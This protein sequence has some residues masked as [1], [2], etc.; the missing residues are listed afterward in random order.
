MN[1]YAVVWLI[2][3]ITLASSFSVAQTA[4]IDSLKKEF[5]QQ[6]ND[7][8][9]LAALVS[10]CNYHQSINK[11]SLYAY[12]LMANS[13]SAKTKTN[14]TAAAII[15][16]NA[17][18]RMGKTD[19]ALSI[20]ETNLTTNTVAN[21]ATRPF[22]F[23]LSAIKA[24]CFGDAANYT[25]ALAQLYKII[26]EAET[27][28]DPIVLAKN[29]NTIGVIQYNLDHVPEAFNWYFKGLSYTSPTPG[30]AA[31][32]GALYINLAETY[33]WVG[34]TD[35]ATYF[36]DKAIPLCTQSQ[37]LFFLGNA[38]RVKASI[39]KQQKDY[40]K[41]EETMLASIAI[42]EKL[43]GKLRFSNE[44]IALANI[45]MNAGLYDKAI[46]MLNR[47]LAEDKDETKADALII[48]YYSTLAKCYHQKGDTKNYTSTLEKII[49]A[50]DAFYEA[51]SAQAIAELQTKYELQKKEKTIIQQK[52]NLTVKNYWLY[53][54]ALF[55]AMMIVIVWL[56]FKNYRRKQDVKMQ[57]ALQEEKRIAAQSV[58]DAEEQERKRI[59]ADLHD[60]IGAYA[61]A[62]RADVEKITDN[63][64]EKN[65][66][67]LQNLQQHSQEIINSLRDTIWVLNK[68]HIT[69]TGIG[70]RIKNYINKLQ[71]TY[72]HIRFQV[73]ED[74]SNDARLSSKHAL[75]IFRIVQEAI[76]NALKH[77]NASTLKIEIH[78]AANIRFTIADD[79]KGIE[80]N[81]SNS[82]GN[83]LLNMKARAKDAGMQLKISSP[84]NKGTSLILI[85]T[86]N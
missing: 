17:Y 61:S 65:H 64:F 33:R 36:I 63:G 69:I 68:E 48:S 77:S 72:G 9:K 70:D 14:S 16:A 24:D 67:S 50:K 27:Y 1:K 76:H 26:S 42:K 59:A 66:A 53:G 21:P 73:D 51:N 19:S 47:A 8:K 86:T 46:A 22:Y 5:T 45:Y 18:L 43:E 30:F 32:T 25:D 58:V 84:N 28:N 57:L 56:G 78:S 39:Y 55:A 54:S 31:V 35:S 83:G 29:I 6:T 82:N 81:I 11:D 37:N 13:L 79:G 80:N 7:A 71:P 34:K 62:I 40:A 60:N 20:A 10:L 2:C 44:Q 3:F 15:L 85:S 41:A 52:L 4:A 75:A 23:T 49:G 12:A 38:I 74:I